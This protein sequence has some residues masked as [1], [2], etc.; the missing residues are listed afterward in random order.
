MLAGRFERYAGICDVDVQ[1]E[2][3]RT[4]YLWGSQH[5]AKMCIDG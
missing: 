5:A 1:Q 4:V 3:S 2:R